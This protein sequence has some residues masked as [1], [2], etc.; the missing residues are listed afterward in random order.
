MSSETNVP[1]ARVARKPVSSYAATLKMRLPKN[2]AIE[3]F[4]NVRRRL[5]VNKELLA[6]LA[7]FQSDGAELDVEIDFS[8]PLAPLFGFLGHSSVTDLDLA[9]YHPGSFSAYVPPSTIV[10]DAPSS[11]SMDLQALEVAQSQPLAED[12]APPSH[13]PPSGA[14]MS[15]SPP[16]RRL[17]R[18]RR[19]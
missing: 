8:A 14:P 9:L 19:E 12:A 3:L 6:W 7:T 11:E 2:V 16:L 18:Q 1:S 15:S 17:K 10:I 13:V 5:P 4:T